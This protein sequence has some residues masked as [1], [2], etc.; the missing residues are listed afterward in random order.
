MIKAK[1]FNFGIA[2]FI[3]KLT[4]SD[5]CNYSFLCVFNCTKLL[6]TGIICVVNSSFRVRIHDPFSSYTRVY[7]ARE[8]AVA[9]DTTKLFL[10]DSLP[11]F[12][13]KIYLSKISIL[14]WL[15]KHPSWRRKRTR[16]FGQRGLLSC[17]VSGTFARGT[18][19]C[20]LLHDEYL[21]RERVGNRLK[22]ISTNILRAPRGPVL[23]K[24]TPAVHRIPLFVSLNSRHPC[25]FS[26][27]RLVRAETTNFYVEN[28]LLPFVQVSRGRKRCGCRSEIA[29]CLSAFLSLRL[30]IPPENH[31]SARPCA[32]F[33]SGANNSPPSSETYRFRETASF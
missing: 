11:S 2:R 9:L 18:L 6:F 3:F 8:T 26:K 13:R 16:M 10:V 7:L 14:L 19:E 22:T 30:S 17:A 33:P 31:L 4:D 20:L 24:F 27:Q 29:T 15:T 32:E 28:K 21:P 23:R 25:C 12:I 1:Y 5:S